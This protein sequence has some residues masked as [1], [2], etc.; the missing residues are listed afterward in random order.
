MRFR[1]AHESSQLKMTAAINN[2][3][4][5]IS[6]LWNSMRLYRFLRYLHI[7]V[8]VHSSFQ[9]HGTLNRSDAWRLVAAWMSWLLHTYIWERFFLESLPSFLTGEIGT[10]NWSCL[11]LTNGPVRQTSRPT[12]IH[13]TQSSLVNCER[14]IAYTLLP[15]N[16]R[17]QHDASRWNWTGKMNARC[18]KSLI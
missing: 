7:A 2:G 16:H 5:T 14:K 10:S 6:M 8:P 15:H 17:Y 18:K 11:K 1:W 12:G 9:F 3:M 4:Y 13:C